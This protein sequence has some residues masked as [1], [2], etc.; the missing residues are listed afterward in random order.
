MND[1]SQKYAEVAEDTSRITGYKMAEES[2][3]QAKEEDED[4]DVRARLAQI[5]EEELGETEE[6]ESHKKK[7]SL[8][9]H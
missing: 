1:A 7:S 6:V 9:S 2:G 5:A 8:F 3:I 4:D